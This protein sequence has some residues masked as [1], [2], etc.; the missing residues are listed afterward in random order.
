M[1]KHQ[2]RLR[3]RLLD[4]AREDLRSGDL[5]AAVRRFVRLSGLEPDNPTFHL[6]RGELEQRRA[7]NT[8]AAEAF[9]TA[10]G[11]FEK[12]AFDDKA[13]SL[14]KRALSCDPERVDLVFA[15]ASSY[16][17][18]GRIREAIEL[19]R[20][21]AADS[22][23]AGRQD[24]AIEL[25]RALLR[26]QPDAVTARLRLAEQLEQSEREEEA[27]IEYAESAIS[28]AKGI[29]PDGILRVFGRIQTLIEKGVPAGDSM[30]RLFHG[31]V[32]A[33]SM[34]EK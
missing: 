27:L 19:L 31:V 22:E 4:A 13:I 18:I 6:K 8:R 26:L 14:F 10:A 5:D 33:Y 3:K 2:Q 11:L 15:L 16:S 32:S 24:E 7:Q 1:D 20:S 12:G 21:R 28:L 34:A 25:H 23:C 17:K 30:S 9:G 29:D